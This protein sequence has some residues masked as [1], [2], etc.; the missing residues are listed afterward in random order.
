[1]PNFFDI[2]IYKNILIIIIAKKLSTELAVELPQV[3]CTGIS[4][5]PFIF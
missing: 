4:S 5:F 1:M 2:S 3:N